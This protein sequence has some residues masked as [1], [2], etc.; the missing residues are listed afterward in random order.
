[1]TDMKAYQV[2]SRSRVSDT[3]QGVV[4]K[5]RVPLTPDNF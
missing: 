2:F 3:E 1:M 5:T 4:D